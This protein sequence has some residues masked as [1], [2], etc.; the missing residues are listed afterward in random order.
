MDLSIPAADLVPDV[1]ALPLQAD[2]VPPEIGFE[3]ATRAGSE[4]AWAVVDASLAPD[5]AS[6]PALTFAAGVAEFDRDERRAAELLERALR[7]TDERWVHQAHADALLA[8][9]DLG[10]ALPEIERLC[11]EDPGDDSAQVL[12]RDAI[13]SAWERRGLAAEAPCACECGKARGNCCGP[14][15]DAALERFADRG[16]F[17]RLRLDLATFAMRPEF[18]RHRLNSAASWFDELPAEI[19]AGD[20]VHRMYV[21]WS[22]TTVPD[23]ADH[24]DRTVLDRFADDPDTPED[25]RRR[26]ACW[27]EHG[28]YGLWQVRRSEPDPGVQLVELC[29]GTYR[30]AEVP[31]SMQ[32][33]FVPWVVML[34]ALVPIDGVWRVG[35]AVSF[36]S[37]SEADHMVAE[38]FNLAERVLN[39]ATDEAPGRGARR[40]ATS[41]FDPQEGA[42]PPSVAVGTIP[43]A[44]PPVSE[45]L[46]HLVGAALPGLLQGLEERRSTP[47]RLLNMEGHPL[48]SIVARIRVRDAAALP[49]LL[50]GHPDVDVG[51]EQLVWLGDEMPPDQA[52]VARAE[53]QAFARRQGTELEPTDGPQRWTRGQVRLLDDEVV[54]ETNSRERLEMFL[55]LLRDLGETPEVV[56]ET[57]V[58]PAQDLVL[59]GGP[60]GS[61]LGGASCEALD[62]WAREWP[63]VPVPALDG[64]TPRE[65]ASDLDL[66]P[67]LEGLLREFEFMAGNLRQAGEAAPDMAAVRADIGMEDPYAW[68]DGPDD[69]T[70]VEHLD[71]RAWAVPPARGRLGEVQL[72]RLDPNDPDERGLLIRA[73]HPALEKALENDLDDVRVGGHDVNPRLHLALHEAIANQLWE[74]DPPEVWQTAKRLLGLGYERHEVLHMLASAMAQELWQ[75]LREEKPHDH[76]RHVRSLQAL[77]GGWETARSR[78]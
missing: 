76:A 34:G 33:G 5:P 17:D 64:L 63:D 39:D 38:V 77:P 13:R 73:E 7:H 37:P 48:I 12:Y 67:R 19:D 56:D 40:R 49:V 65:A 21:E 22:T 50:A 23:R 75:A 66:R 62:A 15:E 58:D 10:S 57:R 27:A 52:A 42:V 78:H 60:P 51:D 31:P 28:V 59:T 6:V 61:L 69:W 20:A 16:N 45:L 53:L 68:S 8:A 3:V 54:L 9:G 46:G 55:D 14:V 26:A 43:P 4:R 41:F 25:D 35:S 71:R 1:L 11:R 74:D 24:E 2:T 44:P 32:E 36:L 70:G 47:P 72:A 30:Y 29:T 18:E